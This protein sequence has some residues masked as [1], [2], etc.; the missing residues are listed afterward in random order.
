MTE[1]FAFKQFMTISNSAGWLK[2]LL[3]WTVLWQ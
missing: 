2:N 1:E 3:F